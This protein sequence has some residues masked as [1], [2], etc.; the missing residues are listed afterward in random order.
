MTDT[1]ATP[2]TDC[3]CEDVRELMACPVHE[4][5]NTTPAGDA[6]VAAWLADLEPYE[7][8]EREN[9]VKARDIR[10]LLYRITADAETIRNHES[11]ARDA[12][13]YIASLEAERVALRAQVETLREVLREMTDAALTDSDA[14]SIC[15]HGTPQHS[16]GCAKAAAEALLAATEPKG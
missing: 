11:Q 1:K 2:A 14:C 15:L 9:D 3:T 13:V 5:R 12:R 7:D 16:S 6:F 8:H 4:P 10:S